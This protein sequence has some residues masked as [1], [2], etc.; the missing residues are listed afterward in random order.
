MKI[1]VF[2]KRTTF[3]KDYGGLETQNKLLCEGLSGRGHSVTVFSPQYELS[4]TEK[5]EGKVKYLFLPC[6][7][8]TLFSSFIKDHWYRVSL[9]KFKELHN[10]KPFDLVVSQSSAAISV[11]K[12][13][14]RLNIPVLTISHGSA[15]T[16]MKTRF[17]D[18]QGAKNLVKLIPDFAYAVYNF[19]IK[20]REFIHGS[21]KVVAVSNF[22]KN[23]LIEETYAPEKKFDVVHNGVDPSKFSPQPASDKSLPGNRV[24]YVGQVQKTKGANYFTQIFSDSRFND[25]KLEVVGSGTYFDKLNEEIRSNGLG[26]NIK[27]HGKFSDYSDVLSF[28]KTN[29]FGAFIFPTQRYEGFPMVLVE[30]MLNG[31]PVIAFNKGGV[32]D[33]VTNGETGFL[34]EPGDLATFKD[35]LAQVLSDDTLRVQMS[36]K[37][38]AKARKDF[39]IDSMLDKYEKIM[40][41]LVK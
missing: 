36:K 35:R 25:V 23:S 30:A 12:R 3:H 41:E 5:V 21:T 39:S 26:D 22:V 2:I 34:V 4:T 40:K 11:I 28:Y 10:E 37:A 16:E 19:F 20:Q 24:L 38:L 27:L 33:A 1:A 29:N 9:E 15:T 8:R 32:F 17:Q 13:K 14:E 7:F 6:T 31:L 18:I